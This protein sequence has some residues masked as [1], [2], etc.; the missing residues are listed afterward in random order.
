MRKVFF[1][2]LAAI[3]KAVLP[4]LRHRDLTRLSSLDKALVAWRYWVTT[5]ALD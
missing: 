5:N 3:N 2:A 4:T 1:K